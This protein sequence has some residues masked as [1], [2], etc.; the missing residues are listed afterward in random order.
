M[1]AGAPVRGRKKNIEMKAGFAVS[2][3]SICVLEYAS[4]VMALAERG[5]KNN[6]MATEAS[7]H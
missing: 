3:C 7:D 6:A 5:D 1:I 2:L 4:V